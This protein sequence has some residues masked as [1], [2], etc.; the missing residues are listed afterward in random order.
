MGA[1]SG[2]F[3]FDWEAAGYHHAMAMAA[4]PVSPLTR[5]RYAIFYLL[6]MGRF[7]EAK[8][9][10]RL[11]LENDPVSLFSHWGLAWSMLAAHE[12]QAAIEY[13]RRALE[14][15]GNFHFMWAP[16]GFA[17]I[18]LGRAKEATATFQ[19]AV[20]AAPWHCLGRM[21]L[22]AAYHLAGDPERARESLKSLSGWQLEFCEVFYATFAGDKDV[23]Y[24][25]LD[26]AYERRDYVQ[27]YLPVFDVYRGEPRFQELLRKMHLA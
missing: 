12:Y 11:A 4:E 8:E 27:L 6:H 16:M 22:A 5:Y 25:R 15:E 18:M 7:E 21:G 2:V 26:Q 23:M 3:D 1:I 20:D 17:Q 10:C 19:R 9:Q 13:A 14:I 24:E